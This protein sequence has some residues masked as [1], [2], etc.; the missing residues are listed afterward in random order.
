MRKLLLVLFL[1]SF[2]NAHSQWVQM[3][4]G[5]PA[6]T[7]VYSLTS[8]GTSIYAGTL[9]GVYHTSNYGVDWIPIGLSNNQIFGLNSLGN[10]LYAGTPDSGVFI[11]TN[12]GVNWLW[13]GLVKNIYCIMV[14]G[15][16]LFAGSVDY[17]TPSIGG[18]Y[19]STNGGLNWSFTSLNG[20]VTSMAV[21]GSYLL[22]G[23]DSS[24]SGGNIF[25]SSNNGNNW[26]RTYSINQAVYSLSSLGTSFLAGTYD[27][28]ENPSG[29]Y[30]TTNNGIL[31]TQSSLNNKNVFSIVVSGNY[32]FAGIFHYYNPGGVLLSTNNGITWLN[33]NQG[34]GS[35]APAVRSLLIN[36][37]YIF[38]GSENNSV[39][40]RTLS[41]AVSVGSTGSEV[42]SLFALRQNYPNPFNQSSIFKFQCSM[43]GHVNVSVYD[44]TGREVR[45]LVNETLQPGTYEVR[46][47][48]SELNSGVYFVRMTAGEFTD[49]KRMVLLK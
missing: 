26:N 42:P 35:S 46:F 30:I 39:W 13:G 2:L 28:D 10:N 6:T 43:K 21:S 7:A 44:I 1:V 31:W 22:A 16:T 12:N 32:I 37:G 27:Y 49:T 5:L 4:N 45:T 9:S 40:R 15:S 38:L 29:L 20:S 41:E 11:S 14:S 48:G 23:T 33:K 8:I 34:F 17:S 25:I 24:F 19:R 36:N 47:D 3:T 18:V